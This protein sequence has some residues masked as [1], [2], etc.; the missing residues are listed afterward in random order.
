MATRYYRSLKPEFVDDLEPL[1][2]DKSGVT[3]GNKSMLGTFDMLDEDVPRFN[4]IVGGYETRMAEIAR[5]LREDPNRVK[6]LKPQIDELTMDVASNVR[7]G[8]LRAI[9]E[10]YVRDAEKKEKLKELFKDRP[11]EFQSA[12]NER[13]VE[14]LNYD[15]S[16]GM[17]GQVKYPDVAAAWT[18]ER[19]DNWKT[20]A[21]KSMK[22]TLLEEAKTRRIPLSGYETLTEIVRKFGYTPEDIKEALKGTFADE[23]RRS[24]EQATKWR[25][26]PFT[27]DEYIDG[28]ADKLANSIAGTTKVQTT[29]GKG[30]D[31]EK[32]ARAGGGSEIEDLARFYYDALKSLYTGEGMEENIGGQTSE[33]FKGEIA[34][35]DK[36]VVEVYRDREDGKLKVAVLNEENEPEALDLDRDFVENILTEKFGTATGNKV[37]NKVYDM[38]IESGIAQRE[39]GEFFPKVSRK[40]LKGKGLRAITPNE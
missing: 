10:R 3:R 40:S 31:F 26:L 17:F 27:P 11:F 22:E 18:R 36:K 29:T 37:V 9:K 23:D 25:N 2:S 35:G 8:E 12:L 33:L 19:E 28:I 15:P 20:L 5:Q 13:Q 32:R 14:P 4:E 24:I 1:M 38:F 34:F 21:L 16:T 6:F 30:T 7:G 39:K